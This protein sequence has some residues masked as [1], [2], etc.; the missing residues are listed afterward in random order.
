MGRRGPPPT[1]TKILQMRGSWRG[2]TREG[3]PEPPPF[4][5]ACPDYLLPLAKEAWATVSQQLATMGVIGATDANVLARY[6]QVFAL[7][8]ETQEHIAE[9]GQVQSGEH[10][11]SIHPMA[12]LGIKYGEQLTRLEGILGLSP[13]ARANLAKKPE[14]KDADD[15]FFGKDQTA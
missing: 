15:K 9:H 1:P 8:R 5:A 7:W 2:D 10:G 3:E 4:E 11:D 6:C 12:A 13:A 14:A